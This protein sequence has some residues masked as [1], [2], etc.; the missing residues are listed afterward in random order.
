MTNYN[1]EDTPRPDGLR[2]DEPFS[3]QVEITHCVFCYEEYALN[4]ETLMKY[5]GKV[6]SPQDEDKAT[7]RFH[8][9]FCD[10]KTKILT[11]GF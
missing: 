1:E 7:K 11:M 3:T 5:F 4:G 8:K 6:R 10:E 9:D 2:W